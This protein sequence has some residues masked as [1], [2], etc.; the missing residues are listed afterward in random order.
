MRKALISGRDAVIGDVRQLRKW[1]EVPAKPVVKAGTLER[2]DLARP[3]D[4]NGRNV[5]WTGWR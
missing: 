5:L 3:S 2:E 1:S 4:D